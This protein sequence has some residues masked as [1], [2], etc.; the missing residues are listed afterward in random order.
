MAQLIEDADEVAE[1]ELVEAQP[2]VDDSVP[3]HLADATQAVSVVA[4]GETSKRATAA[5]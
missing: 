5:G 1:R 4:T 2:G 3:L